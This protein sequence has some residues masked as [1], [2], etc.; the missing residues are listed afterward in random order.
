M[1]RFIF[2][3][4]LLMITVNLNFAND[5]LYRFST[6]QDTLLT[7]STKVVPDSLITG[8]FLTTKIDTIQI[9]EIQNFATNSDYVINKKE[10]R[11]TSY[12]TPIDYIS[13]L[14]NGYRRYLGILGQPDEL[15]LYGFG[16][17]NVGYFENGIPVNNKFHNTLDLNNFQSEYIDSVEVIS[18]ARSFVYSSSN[19]PVVV[20]F[21][22]RNSIE[23]VPF[24]RLRILQGSDEEGYIDAIFNAYVMDKLN[25][26]FE[27][28]N[29]SLDSL[30]GNDSYGTWQG[31]ARVRYLHSE[32]FNL[33]GSFRLVKTETRLWGGIDKAHA[34]SLGLNLYDLGN[35]SARVVQP[36]TYKK[37]TGFYYDLRAQ[38]DL[39]PGFTSELAGYYQSNKDEFRQ[40]END[41]LATNKFIPVKENNE[42]YTGGIYFRQPM[43]YKSIGL[44]IITRFE[45]T[46]YKLQTIDI[47]KT[48]STFSVGGVLSY[49]L[50]DKS[51]VNAFS[52]YL[53]SDELSYFGFG[54]EINVSLSDNLKFYGGGSFSEKPYNI[55]EQKLLT[56]NSK[57]YSNAFAEARLGY[58]TNNF[59]INGGVFFSKQTNATVPLFG[60]TD[61]TAATFITSYSLADYDLFGVN[62]NL[63]GKVS[64]IEYS[65]S[66]T[67]YSK[68][69]EL[70]IS[71]EYTVQ[72][73]IFY[74]SKLFEDNLDLKA[75]FQ[76]TLAGAQSGFRY[77]YLQSRAGYFKT[78]N[79]VTSPISSEIDPYFNLDLVITG[80]VQDRAIIYFVIENILSNDFYTV[81]FYPVR[82]NVVRFGVSWEFYD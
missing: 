46:K 60:E 70:N 14:P 81:P 52:K 2:V 3:L 47:N 51:L 50:S 15:R 27:V 19:D 71:P 31:S 37:N 43:K 11:R 66:G 25:L 49:H 64:K 40:N 12:R 38:F 39:I 1:T 54:G 18:P 75:G 62:L 21:N 10:Y 72:A 41:S 76:G 30:V 48:V 59:N 56:D 35:A 13:L 17:T 7:D 5:F 28:T 61:S 78:N 23:S 9:F 32:S 82:K 73:G 58:F 29:A 69:D 44:D 20:N 33:I 65:L 79:D 24:T 42:S 55:F 68:Q 22:T 6:A 53:I 67:Y 74:K 63:S 57:K 4:T 80:K 16:N 45:T 26:T 8:D 36:R 77:D 34:D